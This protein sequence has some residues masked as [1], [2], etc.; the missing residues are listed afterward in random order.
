MQAIKHGHNLFKPTGEDRGYSS[1]ALL[2]YDG[3]HYDPLVRDS[4]GRAPPQG[5]FPLSNEGVIGEAL[6]IASGACKVR[7]RQLRLTQNNDDSGSVGHFRLPFFLLASIYMLLFLQARQFTDL[8]KFKLRCLVCQRALGG[9]VDAMN[10][11]KQTGHS[12]FGE[13]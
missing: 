11:A 7:H 1:R 6:H 13:I 9:Q 4:G 12:N 5:V 2:L 3:I 10:H 8:S